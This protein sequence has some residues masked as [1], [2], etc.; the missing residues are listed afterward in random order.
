MTFLRPFVLSS[1]AGLSTVLGSFIIFF[2]WQEK[3]INKF[4]T[5]CL[6][7]SLTI[8]IGISVLEL[9]PEAS[10]LIL[11]KFKLFKGLCLS[12]VIFVLAIFMI[13]LM[14]KKIE[15]RRGEESLYRLGLLSMLTLMMHNLPEGI[16]TFL[17]SYQNFSL[18]LRLSV[19]IMLHNIPEGIS[20]AVPIYFATK[21]K[22]K[23]INMTL[24][25][26]LA[27]PFGAI[28]AFLFLKS[29]LSSE[30]IGIILLFVGGIMITLAIEELLPKALSY[31]QEKF[32]IYGGLLGIIILILNHLL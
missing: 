14:N 8:M 27:E 3:N 31:H 18:G 10:Y 24:L 1:L 13:Q 6:S 26:G 21:S 17:S 5:F 29:F 23:A 7:L 9:I 16:L 32:L 12:F 20:I 25:S 11:T 15:K 28:L 30:F 19:A 22:K 2:N 4:I